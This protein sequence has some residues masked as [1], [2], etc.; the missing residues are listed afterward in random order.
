[1]KE[2]IMTPTGASI[3][4]VIVRENVAR[5][6][7]LMK[8]DGFAAVI[9]FDSSNMLAFTGTPHA[10]WDRL[11]CAAVTRAGDV[12][13]VCPAFERPAVS[14]AE[15]IATIHTWEEHEDAFQCFAR[16][17]Q[18]AGV[19]S[20][21]LGLDGRTWLRA[22]QAFEKVCTG[23]TLESAE[24]LI[25]EVRIIKSPAAQELL[26][27]AHRRGEQVFFA[28]RDMIRPGVSEIELHRQLQA[29]FRPEGLELDPMIQS[30]P[31]GAVPHNPTGARL[32]QE[33]DNLVV[34]SVITA[35]GFNNDLTRTFAIG[36][37]GSRAKLAYKAVRS[38]QAAAI[39]AARPGVQCRE[40]DGIAR[41]IIAEAGFGEFFTHRLGHG[42]GI[43][44]H[45]PP[46][47]DGGNTETLRPGMCMTVEP[48]VYV[49]GEFGVR[50]EDDILITERGCEVIEGDLPTDMTDAFD[51]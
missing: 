27:A 33:G 6:Q 34:D 23:L 8:P 38:A 10:A 42:M 29:R 45:E 49:P 12:H 46:Y 14:G 19:R 13:L 3:P 9:V 36:E 2:R 41:R 47:L 26:R 21:K 39:E 24:H 15:D 7:N 37:P 43:E 35:D 22:S 16:A 40:L 32:L 4:A 5:L 51:R 50:I 48:G 28:M 44:C 17:L 18:Q 25:R 30:G 11:T 31:N 20:G 1:V